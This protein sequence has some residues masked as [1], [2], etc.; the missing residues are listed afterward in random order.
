MKVGT[1][2]LKNQLS[3]YLRRV[4]HGET[5]FVTDRGRV[6]AEL[7][8]VSPARDKDE[9]VLRELEAEGLLTRGSGRLKDF[10][11]VRL[12]GGKSVS[13]MIIEDRR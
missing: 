8:G 13:Q 6:V 10:K 7:R 12:K 3:Y 9:Q 11:P 4:R 5:V 2:K 1:K